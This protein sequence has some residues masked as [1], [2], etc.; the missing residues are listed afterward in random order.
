[1]TNGYLQD[2]RGC[3]SACGLQFGIIGLR[4]TSMVRGNNLVRGAICVTEERGLLINPMLQQPSL[5]VVS[6]FA[7]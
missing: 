5:I 2:V 1:M 6:V 3:E 4:D 7:S